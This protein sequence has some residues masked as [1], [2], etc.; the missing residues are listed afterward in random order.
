MD[1]KECRGQKA[2]WELV[3]QIER[4]SNY[5]V[6]NSDEIPSVTVL[7]KNQRKPLVGLVGG[8]GRLLRNEV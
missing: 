1:Y 3:V 2:R 4:K 6:V 8:A 5:L 7:D